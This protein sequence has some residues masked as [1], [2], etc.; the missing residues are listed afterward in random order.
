MPYPSKTNAQTILMAAIDCLE[1]FGKEALSMRELASSL[2]ISPR[3]LYRY[4]P[5]RATLEAAL[6][7]E[8][9]QRLRKALIDAVATSTGKDA[10]RAS[11]TAYL[12]FAHAHPAWYSLLISPHEQTPGLMQAEHNT[13]TFVVQ[14]VE[15]IVGQEQAEGAAVAMWALLHGFIQL[16]GAGVFKE[17]PQSGFEWGLEAFLSGLAL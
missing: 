14:L 9:F 17:K 6:A 12:A 4:Y 1:Q 10:L 13:W 15:N 7:E 2:G 8:G 16:E 5:D 3:A 11:A